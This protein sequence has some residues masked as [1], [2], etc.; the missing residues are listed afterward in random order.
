MTRQNVLL[1]R[2]HTDIMQKRFWNVGYKI[3]LIFVSL[4]KSS[5]EADSTKEEAAKME[6][7]YEISKD[8]TKNEEQNAAENSE[9][10]RG[11][12]QSLFLLHVPEVIRIFSYLQYY[13]SI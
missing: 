1:P 4:D 11:T 9:E 7:E 13:F 5:E 2:D 10:P 6:K 3:N 12:K 8:S